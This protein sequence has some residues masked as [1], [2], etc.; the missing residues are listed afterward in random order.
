VPATVKTVAMGEA[1]EE[2]NQGL[3]RTLKD[4]FAGAAGGV[5]QVLIGMLYHNI[6]NPFKSK[7]SVSHTKFL[8]IV[9]VAFAVLGIATQ[10]ISNR[11]Q[12]TNHI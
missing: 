2:A 11:T 5:A 10:Y 7:A 9:T 4:L 6:F 3:T 12:Y 8:S 1:L